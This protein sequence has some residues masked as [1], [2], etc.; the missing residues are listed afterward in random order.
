ML[1]FSHRH[2]RIE[3]YK[4][5]TKMKICIKDFFSKCDQM[6]SFLRIWSHLLKKSLMEN[7]IFC[8]VKT[9]SR[10]ACRV[11]LELIK[12]HGKAWG[13]TYSCLSAFSRR[14][15]GLLEFS[16]CNGIIKV[17]RCDLM[18]LS[19]HSEK[20]HC[21]AEFLKHPWRNYCKPNWWF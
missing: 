9:W 14:H 7:L 15:H 8:A 13:V 2:S 11:F 20:Q 3:S 4:H 18:M 16:R 5:C 21:F 10:D 17:S 6:R 19:G 1:E 12:K